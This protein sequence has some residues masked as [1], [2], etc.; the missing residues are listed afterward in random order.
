MAF[1][2][3]YPGHRQEEVQRCIDKAAAFIEKI[4][5]PDGSWFVFHLI[6]IVIESYGHS[7]LY[8]PCSWVLHC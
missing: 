2:I 8:M 7:F 6:V 1:K 3:L 4:Q 5:E